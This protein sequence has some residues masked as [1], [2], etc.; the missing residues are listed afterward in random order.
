M[1][2]TSRKQKT[3]LGCGLGC[4]GAIVLLV[5]GCFAFQAWLK[6]PGELLEPTAMLDP[7]ATTYVACR[8]DLADA[9]THAFVEQMLAAAKRSGKQL[10]GNNTSPL[11]DF[12]VSWNETRQRRDLTRLFPITAAW[13]VWPG[14]HDA[15]SVGAVSVSAR[16]MGHQVILADWVLGLIAGRSK[17][18]PTHI[19]AGERVYELPIGRGEP[20]YVFLDPAGAIV[21]FDLDSVA[22]AAE[23]LRQRRAAAVAPR[24]PTALEQRLAAVPA[25]L[26]LRGAVID[27]H[28]E[29]AQLLGWL[30]PEADSDAWKQS[31]E[32]IK[33][34]TVAGRFTG[35]AGIA[36]TL[37]L[38]VD[39][40]T[41]GPR[42]ELL[43]ADL[44]RY[45]GEHWSAGKATAAPSSQ[46]VTLDLV[47][48][49]LPR[50]FEEMQGAGT[51]ARRSG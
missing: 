51:R 49:E 14:E 46:G 4:G 37:E 29:I 32:P 26:P 28:G 36:L 10:R 8:L 17:K 43:L 24:A 12:F 9:P 19:I 40:A 42:R 11:M 35:G 39:P 25:N 41:S 34:A 22:P 20:I 7:R 38:A 47:V 45:F 5:G 50:R 31:W 30:A 27:S 2:E 44:Q 21:C 6:S 18:W 13:V 16:G 23:R 33:S 3:L 1:A 48:D 15:E